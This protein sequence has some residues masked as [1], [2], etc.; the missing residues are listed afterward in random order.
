M[1][2]PWRG[3]DVVLIEGQELLLLSCPKTELLLLLQE[4]QVVSLLA[5]FIA[6]NSVVVSFH[7]NEWLDKRQE[8]KVAL[9]F[10]SCWCV[11]DFF[12]W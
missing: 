7:R 4:V 9:W 2:C 1:A 5:R 8:R 11:C 3:L 10:L 12:L 6:Q